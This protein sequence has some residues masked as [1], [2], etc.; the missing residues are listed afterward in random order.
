MQT[1]LSGIRVSRTPYTF[2]RGTRLPYLLIT[3][4]LRF[5][6][7]LFFFFPASVSH[8]GLPDGSSPNHTIFFFFPHNPFNQRSSLITPLSL[9]S[10][11]L[12][13]ACDNIHAQTPVNPAVLST[14]PDHQNVLQQRDTPTLL[15]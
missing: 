5:Y 4:L 13:S 14:C 7:L 2:L 15:L 9:P 3:Y 10:P 12:T 6:S 11:A 1:C 8:L